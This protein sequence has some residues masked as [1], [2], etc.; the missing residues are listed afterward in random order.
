MRTVHIPSRHVS[1]SMGFQVCI[2]PIQCIVLME[3]SAGWRLPRTDGGTPHCSRAVCISI[4]RCPRVEKRPLWRYQRV[5]VDV[6]VDSQAI[7][8][9]I[10]NASPV[11]RNA[12]PSHRMPN[13]PHVRTVANRHGGGDT[14]Y[15]AVSET[16]TRHIRLDMYRAHS[17]IS[18]K[19]E[20][21]LPNMSAVDE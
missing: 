16:V 3:W 17:D 14:E 9:S 8:Q 18:G 10:M 15:R 5:S 1:R 7:Y 20:K 13:L 11:V 19:V 12:S 4:F 6:A 21:N 2:C